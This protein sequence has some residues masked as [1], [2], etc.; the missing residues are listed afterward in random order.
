MNLYDAVPDKR[1]SH[2]VKWVLVGAITI[3]GLAL[4]ITLSL[5]WICLLS[6]KERAARR[7]IEVKDQVNPESSRKDD[8]ISNLTLLFSTEKNI[9]N[10]CPFLLCKY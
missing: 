1:S 10:F 5:L 7:Y 3:M 9:T 8:G 6:K 2:Y 4:V